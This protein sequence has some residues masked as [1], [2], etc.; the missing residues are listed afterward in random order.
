M[1][2]GVQTLLIL[3]E[4]NDDD[5]TSLMSNDDVDY[6]CNITSSS[7]SLLSKLDVLPF[8]LGDLWRKDIDVRDF[9]GGTLLVTITRWIQEKFSDGRIMSLSY[10][11]DTGDR[12]GNEKVVSCEH[13]VAPDLHCLLEY[14]AV[15]GTTGHY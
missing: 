11:T 3:T 1:G 15:H 4:N 2:E 13:V 9:V 14:E 6:G 5:G 7:V 12:Y 10:G 8:V